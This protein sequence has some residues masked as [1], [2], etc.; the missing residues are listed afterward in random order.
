MIYFSDNFLFH[1]GINSCHDRII[2][3]LLKWLMQG[4][5]NITWTINSTVCILCKMK[6]IIHIQSWSILQ[7]SLRIYTRIKERSHC[8]ILDGFVG[9]GSWKMIC[10]NFLKWIWRQTAPFIKF[11]IDIY[12]YVHKYVYKYVC[13]VQDL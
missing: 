8:A 9:K 5:W 4:P 10:L 13:I 11:C 6:K 7:N 3:W 1:L 12:A 2:N